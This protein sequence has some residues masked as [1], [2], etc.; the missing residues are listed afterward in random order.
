MPRLMRFGGVR[1]DSAGQDPSVLTSL[2]LSAPQ[3]KSLCLSRQ[4]RE[5]GSR[6]PAEVR[7]DKQ[8]VQGVLE[9]CGEFDWA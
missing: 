6:A 3:R 2:R 4:D 1:V 8:G 7:T 5:V 9:C